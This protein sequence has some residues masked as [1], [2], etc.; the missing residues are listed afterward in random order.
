MGQSKSKPEGRNPLKCILDNFVGLGGGNPITKKGLIKR[1]VSEWANYRP[2]QN[3]QWPRE[4]TLKFHML[5]ILSKWFHEVGKV[6]DI[7]YLQLFFALRNRPELLKKCNIEYLDV[8]FVNPVQ[9]LV[10]EAPTAPLLKENPNWLSQR[11]L[12]VS[13]TTLPPSSPSISVHLPPPPLI[14]SALPPPSTERP[15]LT[16]PQMYPALSSLTPPPPKPCHLPAPAQQNV[17]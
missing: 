4:G 2:V 12:P 1:C 8:E 10:A 3:F 6:V 15:S 17:Q 16:S 9:T 7:E 14:Y 13:P 11:A 5:W